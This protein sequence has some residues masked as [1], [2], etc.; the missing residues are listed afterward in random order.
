MA[1]VLIAGVASIGFGFGE[2]ISYNGKVSEPLL[3]F[4]QS[5]S[6]LF[7]GIAAAFIGSIGTQI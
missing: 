5:F 2:L 4:S 7:A 6:L 3:T 1:F